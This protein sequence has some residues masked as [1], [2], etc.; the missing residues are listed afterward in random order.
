MGIRVHKVIGYGLDDVVGDSFSE[1]PRFDPEGFFALDG[2]EEQEEKFPM[3]EFAVRL[4]LTIANS[5]EWTF[6]LKLLN[7]NIRDGEFND[8]YNVLVYDPEYGLPNV[9]VFIPP[10]ANR[11]N[12]RRDDTLDWYEETINHHQQNHYL[13]LNRPIY[14]DVLWVDLRQ[15]PPKPADR[16]VDRLRSQ[17][18]SPDWIKMGFSLETEDNMARNVGFESK[19]DLMDN[20]VPM[21]PEDLVEVLKFLKVFKDPATIYRL[22]PMIYTYWG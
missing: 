1:D 12:R 22:K 17:F 19:Q 21:V 7:N 18:D 2:F 20:V 6:H 10:T 5:T 3:K 13:L 15:S 14:P 4:D 16:L 9:C 8:F 11:N